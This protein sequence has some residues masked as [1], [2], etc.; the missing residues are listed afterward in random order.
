MTQVRGGIDHSRHRVWAQHDRDLPAQQL[1]QWQVGGGQ[2][3]MQNLA[4]EETE[5]GRMHTDGLRVQLA[6]VQM[7]LV[8][9]NLQRAEVIGRTVKVLGEPP[10]SVNVRPYGSLGV[11]A[12]LEFLERHFSK[13]GHRDLL[14]TQTIRSRFLPLASTTR[15][16]RRASGLVQTA[17]A[18]MSIRPGRT[19]EN[20]NTAVPSPRRGLK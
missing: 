18:E 2:A 9:P 5:R 3:L 13:L 4:V 16:V 17:F 7:Q 11:I 6:L 15:S 20:L 14:V 8:L 19:V 12:A 10:D 1:R